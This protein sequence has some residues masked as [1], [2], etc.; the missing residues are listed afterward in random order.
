MP[1]RISTILDQIDSGAIALPVFQ[2]GFVWNRGQVRELMTSLYRGHPVG[3]LLFWETKS[4][5]ARV[6]GEGPIQAG[7]ANLLLDG[8]QRVTSL[9]GLIRGK[10]PPFFEGNS[11]AFTG[12]YFNTVSETFQFYAPVRM[13]QESGWVNV[14]DLMQ[15]GIGPY[16]QEISG[17][18][19]LAP[20]LATHLDRLNTVRNIRDRELHADVVTGADKTVDT[21]VD[22]F[23]RVNRQG[24]TLSKGDLALAK[25]CASWP[26]ARDEMT[27]K[28]ARWKD[29][30]FGFQLEWLLRCVNSLVTGEALFSQLDNVTTEQFQKGL[31]RAGQHVD[32]LL[33]LISSR[34]GLDHGR[35]LGSRYSFPLMVRY[36]EER[37]GTLS[38]PNEQDG[39]LFWYIHTLLWGRYSGNTETVLNQDLD[40]IEEI[41]GGLERLLQGLRRN[42]GDLSINPEDFTGST[43]G[44]RFYPVLYMLT[45][46]NHSLD[47]CD[48]IELNAS[49]LGKHSR[50]ELHHI[51]PKSLLYKK[52]YSKHE[53]NALANFTFLTKPC[54]QEISNKEPACYMPKVKEKW[55]GALESHWIPMNPE[56]WKIE[57]YREFLKTR[58]ELLA[59]AANQFLDDLQSGAFPQPDT[60][61]SAAHSIVGSV[62]SVA[63]EEEEQILLDANIWIIDQDLP[64]GEFGYEIVNEDTG[65]QLAVLD[66]AWPDGL[67]PR[68]SSPIALLIDEGPEVHRLA[69]DAGFRVFTQ[70][71]DLKRYVHE[72]ILD[73]A[74]LEPHFA[75]VD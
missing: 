75:P 57:N 15:R 30:G 32:Y 72:Q 17:N 35:V 69:N 61:E 65:E 26:K 62:S 50:L 66:L 45:R 53:V 27:A 4:D 67:Q 16:I 71:D 33:N 25:V 20:N 31:V 74:S 46:V 59:K 41:D 23:H 40:A 10:Q 55:P 7:T 47:W 63:S 44:A 51:F 12:L 64:E 73:T 13:G 6:R 38:N 49:M 29:A 43:R 70:P 19:A 39:V 60:I 1:T 21:V 58:R 34:L 52:G 9:Y 54:N 5:S 2:R 8:Q 24:T 18:E 48:G 56:L 14:T 22:I 11:N 68:L 42:R 37:G 3:S 36:L 28:L